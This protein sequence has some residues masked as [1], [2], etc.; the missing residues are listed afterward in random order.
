[1]S[2]ELTV[3][4]ARAAPGG[5]GHLDRGAADAP[6]ARDPDLD[7]A[8][9]SSRTRST[10]AS[11][12]R[13][14]SHRRVDLPAVRVRRHVQLHEHVARP[15]RRR[16]PASGRRPGPRPLRRRDRSRRACASRD[17]RPGTARAERRSRARRR[18]VARP[19]LLARA[20]RAGDEFYAVHESKRR[21]ARRLRRVPRRGQVELAARSILHVDDLVTLTP[22]ARVALWR[23][24]CDVD[25]V[26][27]IKAA[28]PAARR[29]DPVAAPGVAPP[30]GG[31]HDRLAVA[32]R[33]S[34]CP[35]RSASRA[36]HGR[37]QRRAPGRRPVPAPA[38]GPRAATSSTPAPTV[39]ACAARSRSLT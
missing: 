2:F 29:P 20:Q 14:C 8:R 26:E 10:G 33:S 7:Q 38:A 32:T 28:A 24:V 18:V 19:V 12:S 27:T 31:A 4:G 22:E 11:R 34:T 36:V 1:M 25:L 15:P 23:F 6:P 39:R 35:P 13:S 37:G 3:P 21:R 30:A 16:L 9:A 5:C 17:L